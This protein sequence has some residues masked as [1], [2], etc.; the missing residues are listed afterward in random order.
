LTALLDLRLPSHAPY[1]PPQKKQAATKKQKYEK[2]SEKKMRTPFE[3]LCK[4]FPQEFVLYFQYV[5]WGEGGGFL[6]G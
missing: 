5:R 4:G 2:I 6:G 3:S 1:L